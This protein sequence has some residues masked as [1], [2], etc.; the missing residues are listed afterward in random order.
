V[1]APFCWPMW[2]EAAPLWCFL[3]AAGLKA[4]MLCAVY[5]MC[6]LCAVCTMCGTAPS[7]VATLHGAWVMMTYR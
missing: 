7:G 1:R 3:Q 4:A 6:G 2:P 5:G